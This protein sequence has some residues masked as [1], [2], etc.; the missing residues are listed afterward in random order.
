MAGRAVSAPDPWKG[1]RGVMAAALLLQGIVVLLALPVLAKSAGAG[2]GQTG[3]VLVLAVA[4][5]VAAGLQGKPWAVTLNLV[6]TALMIAGFA[7]HPAIG[8][9]GIVFALVWAYIL[10]LRAALR[11]RL[12]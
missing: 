1:L 9:L 5:F 10:F 11:K 6:L 2:W 12:G 7:I 8:A 4:L 3:L